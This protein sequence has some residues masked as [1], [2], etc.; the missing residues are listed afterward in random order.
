M[1]GK[2]QPQLHWKET[3]LLRET[4]RSLMSYCLLPVKTR[5]LVQ[6]SRYKRKIKKKKLKVW[7]NQIK[8]I[9]QI[10]I[11]RIVIIKLLN[12]MKLIWRCRSFDSFQLSFLLGHPQHCKSS[13]STACYIS[14]SRTR[15]Q[16]PNR[17][18]C[19][20]H[21]QQGSFAYQVVA[22]R[23]DSS[24]AFQVVRLSLKQRLNEMQGLAIVSAI[25]SR[26]TICFLI[27]QFFT[28][29]DHQLE[30]SPH[31]VAVYASSDTRCGLRVVIERYLNDT[32]SEA[33]IPA[34]NL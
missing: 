32:P 12:L 34:V 10:E 6:K 27:F 30:Q 18:K 8:R 7:I 14:E 13:V 11:F 2:A 19:C 5:D 21:R 20:A 4:S 16:V 28:R 33:M 23:I 9:W 29:W 3:C 22:T 31:C 17:A 26:L 1:L 25:N 15:Y 24:E